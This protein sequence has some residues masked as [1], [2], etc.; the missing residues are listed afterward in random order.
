[1]LKSANREQANGRLIDTGWGAHRPGTVR[2]DGQTVADDFSASNSLSPGPL[3]Q[4]RERS[5]YFSEERVDSFCDL[6]GCLPD[7]HWTKSINRD[8]L[9]GKFTLR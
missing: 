8:G 3:K 9:S 5:M 2:L 7:A 1:V 4:N 6:I